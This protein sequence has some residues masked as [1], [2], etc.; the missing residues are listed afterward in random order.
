MR[1]FVVAMAALSLACLAGCPSSS[2]QGASPETRSDDVSSSRFGG[3]IRI[4]EAKVLG[5]QD[6]VV[7]P[8]EGALELVNV[9]DALVDLA[10]YTIRIDGINSWQL[11][12]VT[13]E[14]GEFYVAQRLNQLYGGA[15]SFLGQRARNI[16]VIDRLGNEIDY[17]DIP[18]SVS[19][20]VLVRYP[21]GDGPTYVYSL[22]RS[23]FGAINPDI[24]FVRKHAGGT[25]FLQRDSSP[26]AIVTHGGYHWILGGWSNFGLDN[27]HSFSDVWKS[28]DGVLWSLVNDAPPYTHYSSF[29]EWRD[30]M[31]VIGPSSFSSDDGVDWRAE[32]VEAP[33]LNRTVVFLDSLVSIYGSTVATSDDGQHWTTLTDTAPWGSDRVQPTVLVYRDQIWVMGGTGYSDVDEAYFND[34]WVSADGATWNLV[35]PYSNWTPRLWTSGA[36]YDDKIFV[37]N[38]FSLTEWGEEY[39]NTAEIWFTEDGLEWFPLES[40]IRWTPRHASLTTVDEKHGL[41]VLGGYGGGNTL[42]RTYN[43]V[44]SV[45]VA[46]FFSKPE[47]DVRELSTWGKRKDGSGTPP[48]SFDAPNQAFV[49]RNRPSFEIDESWSVRGAGS[50]IFVGDGQ[51]THTV[52]LNIVNQALPEQPLYLLSNST[53]IVSGCSPSVYFKHPEAALIDTA[54]P[55]LAEG[56]PAR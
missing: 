9:S 49:L 26:N 46:V 30:R 51:Q 10:N 25:E 29:V 39:G 8:W 23:T 33:A 17:M 3:S 56:A 54:A 31:W 44:W 48:E 2:E 20:G 14:P 40:E 24:G 22:D 5:S 4:N 15:A 45:H 42:D 50:R 36:V 21:N 47:G 38:G 52:E 28:S 27:W 12:N 37:I 41:L 43:D 13:L 16:A 32:K 34:V 7:Q 55:C 6:V 53:T 11:P 35:N 19:G 18:A 1:V